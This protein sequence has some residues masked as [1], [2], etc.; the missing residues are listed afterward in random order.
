MVGWTDKQ[1]NGQTDGQKGT[2]SKDKQNSRGTSA[3]FSA[4]LRLSKV[5]QINETNAKKKWASVRNQRQAAAIDSTASA[6]S[7]AAVTGTDIPTFH[8]KTK[9]FETAVTQTIFI[10]SD[11]PS[12]QHMPYIPSCYFYHH[13]Y[14]NLFAFWFAI[15][16]Q[17]HR[18]LFCTVGWS[19]WPSCAQLIT[20]L[21]FFFRFS[22][23]LGVCC[24]H[25]LVAEK[26]FRT[27][28]FLHDQM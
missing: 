2:L 3:E 10:A 12:M 27:Q 9:H 21:I 14:L 17:V 13:Y 7:V 19:I 26:S 6:A 11:K 25:Q 15:L 22:L 1:K 23:G 5:D 20:Y 4:P 8:V 16:S 18:Q 24:S 28:S